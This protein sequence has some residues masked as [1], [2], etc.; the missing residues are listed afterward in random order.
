MSGV[1]CPVF[2]HGVE[3]SAAAAYFSCFDVVEG[4]NVVAQLQHPFAAAPRR[5]KVKAVGVGYLYLSPAKCSECEAVPPEVFYRVEM[6]V[7]VV[8][9]LVSQ[10]VLNDKHEKRVRIV[11]VEACQAADGNEI[12]HVEVCARIVGFH[13][14]GV[15]VPRMVVESHV[16]HAAAFKSVFE[17]PDGIRREATVQVL[18]QK[19]LDGIADRTWRGQRLCRKEMGRLGGKQ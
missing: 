4:L 7:C 3:P 16:F 14:H 8:Q 9:A 12:G 2:P 13:V 1:S 10:F 15:V 18:A 5:V 11:F 19:G 17:I 6:A